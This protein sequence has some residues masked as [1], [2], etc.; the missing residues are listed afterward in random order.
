M[1]P[2]VL[3][4]QYQ[5]LMVGVCRLNLVIVRIGL[6]YGPYINQGMSKSIRFSRSGTF[7]TVLVATVLTVAS[8]YGYMKRPMKSL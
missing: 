7:V 5:G 6:V 3:R 8:V 4:V 2:A 1:L